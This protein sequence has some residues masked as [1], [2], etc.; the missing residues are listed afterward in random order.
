MKSSFLSWRASSHAAVSS[1]LARLRTALPLEVLILKVGIGFVQPVLRIVDVSYDFIR[2]NP[3][4]LA[5]HPR[6]SHPSF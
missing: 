1:A 3:V 2:V 4:I 6:C 5:S